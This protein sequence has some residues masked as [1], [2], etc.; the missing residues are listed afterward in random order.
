[1]EKKELRKAMV[2]RRNMLEDE[3]VREKSL[4]ITDKVASLP[5]YQAARLVMAYVSFRQEVDTSFIIT[6]ALAG[7]KKVVVP[8]TDRRAK[9]LVPS[10]IYDYPSELA[11][12]TF[13][14]MEPRP[15]VRRPVDP[16]EIDLVLVPGIAFDRRGNRLGY[17]GGFYDRFL[18]KLRPGVAKAALAYS[19][20][21]V[22]KIDAEPH[23][24]PLDLI[25]TELEVIRRRPCL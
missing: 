14:I 17:G 1:M 3:V 15:E 21:V 4:I 23:D 5:E 20:Q 24:L 9:D 22:E 6:R 13:G 19:F 11:P 2:C 10:E 7:G 12:G 18:R 25:I 8:V 16:A